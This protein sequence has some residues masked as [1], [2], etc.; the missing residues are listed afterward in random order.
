MASAFV[1]KPRGGI[2]L[3]TAQL[4]V[5]GSVEVV[6]RGGAYLPVSVDPRV[7]MLT[8]C[9]SHPTAVLATSQTPGLHNI[10]V[11]PVISINPI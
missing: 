6:A 4:S 1:P 7:L 8:A 5:V 9:L 11:H 10:P 2:S 3:E